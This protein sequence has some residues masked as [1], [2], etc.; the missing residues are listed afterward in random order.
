M[1]VAARVGLEQVHVPFARTCRD[2]SDNDIAAIG[3]LLDGKA[4]DLPGARVLKVL[5]PL[6]VAVRVGLGKIE[7]IGIVT[8]RYVTAIAGLPDGIALRAADVFFPYLVT[9]PVDL[10]QKSYSY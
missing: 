1:L 3:S 8:S 7:I 4:I 6:L 5:I 9:V 2:L 10:D